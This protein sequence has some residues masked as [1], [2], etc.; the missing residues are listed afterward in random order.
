MVPDGT[1]EENIMEPTTFDCKW[2]GEIGSRTKDFII[3]DKVVTY[4]E[5]CYTESLVRLLKS[6]GCEEVTAHER[7]PKGKRSDDG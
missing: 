7:K 4:C 3:H 5:L 6:G 1:N 2:H